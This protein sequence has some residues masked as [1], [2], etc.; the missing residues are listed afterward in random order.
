MKSV[1]ILEDLS[2][3]RRWLSAVVA[4]AFPGARVSEAGTV[5]AAKA[6]IDRE[7][8]D[9]ALVDLNL[10][11]GD[12]LTVL[13]HLQRRAPRT[14]AIV[15]TIMASDSAIVAALSAGADGYVLKSEDSELMERHL[16]Q[17]SSGIPALS[18][19][20]ARRI[21]DH[22]RNTG[23]S[24]EPA[25]DLT[26]RET[27]VLRLIAR[28]MRVSEA[29]AAIGIAE[30]TVATHIKT[31]YRKLGISS[32]AEAAIQAARLGLLNE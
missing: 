30:T 3:T 27:D 13:R 21:M 4:R 20:I 10:P 11:D 9:L 1:L 32:R 16:H 15:S 7:V 5:A 12:G 26:A 17:L 22:F 19:A 6:L 8:F 25:Q 2:E 31:I 28:G 23:P 24:F 29:A 18:P 14:M